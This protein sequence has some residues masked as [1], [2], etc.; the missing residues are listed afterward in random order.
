MIDFG[1][2]LDPVNTMLSALDVPTISYKLMR[3][4]ERQVGRAIMTVAK[5]SCAKIPVC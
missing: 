2:G 1:S 5:D 4:H 3:R